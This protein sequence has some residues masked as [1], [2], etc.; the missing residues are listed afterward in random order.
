MSFCLTFVRNSHLSGR[1]HRFDVYLT[2]EPTVYESMALVHSRVRRVVFGVPDREMGGLGGTTTAG[3]H[4]LPGTNHHFRAFR[5][6]MMVD[7]CVDGD[8]D[9]ELKNTLMLLHREDSNRDF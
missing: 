2:K 6:N 4:S 8:E 9:I 3:I 7:G 5:F 1:L